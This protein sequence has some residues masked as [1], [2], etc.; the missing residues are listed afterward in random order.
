MRKNR[1]W[2]KTLL[3]LSAGT[4][5][6]GGV[7]V[8]FFPAPRLSVTENRYLAPFPALSAKDLASGAYTAALDTYAT[9]RLPAR[10]VCRRVYATSELTLLRAESHGVI[11][12]H[13][14]SLCRR[15][16]VN[17]YAY[18]QNL[19]ALTRLQGMLGEVPLTVAVAPRRI[20]VRCEVLPALYD[21]AREQAAWEQLPAGTVTFLDATSDAHWY[22]TDHHWTNE[23]AYFAYVRLS[24]YLGYTPHP[25]SAFNPQ[26]VSQNFLGSSAAAAGFSQITPDTVSVWRYEGEEDYR[27]LRDGVP[28]SFTGLY[29][30]EKLL[31]ADQY[32]LFLG[33]NCGLLQ[34]DRGEG[35][36]RPVLLMIK[37]SFAN[38]LV[39]FLARHYRILAV[40][41]RYHA[42]G[43]GDLAQSA[44]AALV[45]CGMQTLTQSPFF[46]PLL[47]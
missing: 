26:K 13:D 25:T 43:L 5:L 40:D 8:T 45:L 34:I 4:L 12:C 31:C 29:D 11:L 18:R 28:A 9:E 41:P 27:I 42:G 39:P 23:G 3:V 33:G 1:I 47:R 35:D 7:G 14:G 10:D 36:T 32:S 19:S 44:D 38:S 30:E 24:R 16:A 37:D 22:R 6:L 21:T 2:D 15:L 46:A 20:D 17:D